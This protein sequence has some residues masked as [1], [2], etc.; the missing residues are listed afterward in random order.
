MLSYSRFLKKERRQLSLKAVLTIGAMAVLWFIALRIWENSGNG[1]I[2]DDPDSRSSLVSSLGRTGTAL[3]ST[4]FACLFLAIPLTANMYTPQLISFFVGSKTNTAILCYFVASGATGLWVA[5]LDV[6]T[7]ACVPILRLSLYMCLASLVLLLPYLFSIFRFLD[8][9]TIVAKVHDSIIDKMNTEG[10]KSTALQQ[11]ELGQQ[12]RNLGNVT[13]RAIER[14]D[15]EVAL[16]GVEALCACARHYE[17][18]KNKF[19]SKW[20]TVDQQH[21]PGFSREATE[22]VIQQKSWVEMEVLRQLSRSFTT[23]LAKMPD[24]ISAIS[25]SQRHFALTASDNRDEGAL[26]L[27]L[28]FFNN[29]LREAIIRRDSHAVFDL[30]FQ[31]RILADRLWE[32]SPEHVVAMAKHLGY[33]ASMANH[34]DLEFARDLIALD[35]GHVITDVCHTDGPV[36]TI[37]NHWLSINMNEDDEL[38]QISPGIAKA[39]LL[40]EARLRKSGRNDLADLVVASLMAAQPLPWTQIQQE[41]LDD[42]PRLFWEVTD[43]QEN[44]YFSEP[45]ERPTIEKT[46]AQLMKN[47]A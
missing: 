34:K 6:N 19:K 26:E 39:R 47:S 7:D 9:K 35:L 27:A 18:V 38:I 10:G 36:E 14:S 33:Y 37:L 30:V 40:A 41:L 43:R 3:I 11:E 1:L 20:F 22:A 13:L 4:I 25:R 46:L 12:I 16:S 17:K 8:P 21:F 42:P 24:V 44:L 2:P 29:F 45:D 31:I 5:R 32:T 15:R 23:S 28:R